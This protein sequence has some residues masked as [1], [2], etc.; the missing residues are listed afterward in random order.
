MAFFIT[1]NLV[2]AYKR[3]TTKTFQLT[4]ADAATAAVD[5]VEVNTKFLATTGLGQTKYKVWSDTVNAVAA[6]AGSNKD[7][8]VTI[9]GTN[10]NAEG[11]PLKIP[12]PLKANYVNPDG[13]VD[14]TDVDL[15]AFLALFNAGGKIT[16]SDGDTVDNWEKGTL[17]T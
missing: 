16:I 7:E 3:K 10:Q 17:D 2:D 11:V 8:G 5:A 9:S 14:L 6:D 1:I 4:A 13:S 15:A 12:A